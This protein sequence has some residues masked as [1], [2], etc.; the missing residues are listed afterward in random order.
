MKSEEICNGCSIS[1]RKHNHN[2]KSS[3]TIEIV[4]GTEYSLGKKLLLIF[5]AIMCLSYLE[6]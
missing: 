2:S 4:C 3:I 6:L 1:T 5:K